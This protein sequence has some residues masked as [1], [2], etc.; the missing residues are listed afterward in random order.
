M[1]YRETCS[2]I[3]QRHLQADLD[4]LEQFSNEWLLRF[5][6]NK[7]K[8]LHIALRNQHHNY[9][10]PKEGQRINFQETKLEKGL[11]VHIDPLL[12]FSAPCEK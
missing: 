1:V 6:T 3:D 12:N 2:D 7:C 11:K 8:V 5:K 9:K 4:A 10:M